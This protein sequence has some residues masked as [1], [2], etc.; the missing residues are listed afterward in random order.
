MF[1]RRVTQLYRAILMSGLLLLSSATRGQSEAS[2]VQVAR[3][4]WLAVLNGRY[5][6]A[7][8]LLHPQARERLTSRQF[9]AAVEPVRRQV[10]QRGPAI[11]LYKFGVRIGDTE[12]SQLFY[13]FMFRS[14]TLNP[15]PAVQLDVTFQNEAAR[16]IQSFTTIPALQSARKN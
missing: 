9:R 8:Q 5:P 14:D 11:D 2:Q 4:F 6:E 1:F 13:A 10:Q 16:Q 3:Q 15:V 7:Y 12:A